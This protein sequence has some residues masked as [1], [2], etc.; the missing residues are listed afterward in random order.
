MKTA[1]SIP[2]ELFKKIEH[3]AE[4]H[5]CSRSQVFSLAIKEFM[6]K[7]ES[8][9]LLNTLNKIY[10]EEEPVEEKTLRRKSKKY[11]SKKVLKEPF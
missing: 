10:S 9:D 7:M 1:I 4:E 6:K 11:Y 8:Q 2:D 5:N 3:F